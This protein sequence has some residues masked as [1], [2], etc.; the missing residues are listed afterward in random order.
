L[1][2]SIDALLKNETEEDLYGSQEDSEIMLLYGR[3]PVFDMNS[4]YNTGDRFEGF[5]D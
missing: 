3:G 1:D 2:K 4:D 5:E